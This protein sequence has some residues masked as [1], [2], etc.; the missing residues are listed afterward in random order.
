MKNMTL[1]AL[2][3]KDADLVN[4]KFIQPGGCFPRHLKYN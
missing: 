4:E 2:Y 3:R 1:I